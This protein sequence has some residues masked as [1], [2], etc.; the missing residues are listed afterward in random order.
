MRIRCC[1]NGGEPNRRRGPPSARRFEHAG[2][3]EYLEAGAHARQDPIRTTGR[4]QPLEHV[5][6]GALTVEVAQQFA[7]ALADFHDTMQRR[8]FALGTPIDLARATRRQGSPPERSAC[9]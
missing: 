4:P 8:R 9:T 6:N 1:G 7:E 3:N 2:S 5:R